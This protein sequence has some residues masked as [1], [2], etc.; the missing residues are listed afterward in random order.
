[1]YP[2]GE[3]GDFA[4]AWPKVCMFPLRGPPKGALPL[5]YLGVAGKI[6]GTIEQGGGEYD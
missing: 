2:L 4:L 3:S 5:G 1:M 6:M